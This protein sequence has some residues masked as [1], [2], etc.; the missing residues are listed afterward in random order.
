[1]V[2]RSWQAADLVELL[3]LRYTAP[4]YAFIEQAR[5]GTGWKA[6]RSA[7]GLALSLWPSRG[8]YFAG[9]EI[10]VHRGDWRRELADPAKAEEMA[11]LCRHWWIVAPPGLVDTTELPATWGLLEPASGKGARGKLKT[12]RKAPT[13]KPKKIT[14][15]VIAS[16]LR[17]VTEQYVPAGNVAAQVAAEV[18]RRTTKARDSLA[19]ERKRAADT[20]KRLA[21]FERA[22]G[23]KIDEWGTE[24]IGE[25]VR[26]VRERGVDRV[27]TDL[28]RMADTAELVA[29]RARAEADKVRAEVI[30]AAS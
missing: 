1:M 24:Q 26:Y 18:E 28:E 5:A 12:V 11:A 10:K 27:A 4:E 14:I 13:L 25:A 7:D 9:F 29:K 3:R 23:V 20:L 22:S 21:I 15:D 19:Y 6:N 8:I 30:G 16:L 2:R 17:R